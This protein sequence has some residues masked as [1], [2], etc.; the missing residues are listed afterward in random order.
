[1]ALNKRLLF[2]WLGLALIAL[3]LFALLGCGPSQR[4]IALLDR[5]KCVQDS[6]E[7]FLA[8]GAGMSAM[9]LAKLDSV[10]GYLETQIHSLT[11]EDVSDHISDSLS[12]GY[13]NLLQAVTSKYDSL[14][15]AKHLIAC[16]L[17]S[18]VS[19][20]PCSLSISMIA[21]YGTSRD[22][23]YVSID[24]VGGDASMAS[25]MRIF[26]RFSE[27]MKDST[28]ES[29]VM[30]YRGESRFV[31]QGNYF[32]QLGEE[33]EW[34]NPIYTVRTFAYNLTRPDGTQAFEVPVGP[35]FSVLSDELDDHQA[36][37]REWYVDDELA[38]LQADSSD[39]NSDT[40]TEEVLN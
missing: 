26:L 25:V 2:P 18:V 32:A 28:Y 39:S 38:R 29:V 35:M 8:Q 4:E 34:Q 12:R 5:L 19:S 20:D 7:A 15:T 33:Y 9:Y 16:F 31:M 21:Y 23:L 6:T 14:Y 13:Q 37:H 11:M 3:N 1:M 22:T 30:A 40:V 17:D 27:V 10:G 36:M 24:S